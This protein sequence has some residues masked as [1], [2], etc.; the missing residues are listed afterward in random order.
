MTLLE[1]ID[2]KDKITEFV[3]DNV[4]PLF[5]KMNGDTFDRYMEAGKGLVWTL[6]PATD[7]K[8]FEQ[9]EAEHRPMMSD[10]ARQVKKGY[11]VTITDVDQFGEAVDNML[12]VNKF[13]AIAVHKKAGDKKKYVYDGEM[14]A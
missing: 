6:F 4:L 13:P 7:G 8:N 10:V 11:F 9:V 14:T 3:I 12:S 5:G 2:S 1:G